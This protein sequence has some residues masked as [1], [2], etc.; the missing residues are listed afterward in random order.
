LA[1]T[2]ETE[3]CPNR[4]EGEERSNLLNFRDLDRPKARSIRTPG[5][6]FPAIGLVGLCTK[7]EEGSGGCLPNLD[8]DYL[9]QVG[10]CACPAL[11]R[12]KGKVC[13]FNTNC[14]LLPRVQYIVKY[15]DDGERALIKWQNQPESENSWVRK[16]DLVVELPPK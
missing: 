14:R 16:S 13:F 11:G 4:Y 10:F 3:R 12:N 6:E 7:S 1:L 9:Q 8:S 2:C 5:S 15:S